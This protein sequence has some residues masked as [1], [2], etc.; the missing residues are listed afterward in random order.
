MNAPVTQLSDINPVQQY[1]KDQGALVK[2]KSILG[3]KAKSF[4]TTV[5]Q[6]TV[7]NSQL[8][9]ANPETVYAAAVTAATLDLPVN[10]NFGFAYILPYNVNKKCK[11]NNWK[12]DWQVEAQL[13]IGYKGFI[14]LALRS[15]QFKHINVCEVFADD[16][17]EQIIE[18]LTSL[19]PPR[20]TGEVVGY[21]A[22]FKLLNGFEAHCN[23]NVS[24]L[25]EH[26]Y[27]YSKTYKKAVDD[28]KDYSTWHQNFDAM[29]KKTVLKQLLTSRAPLSVELQRAI[30]TDQA[31]MRDVDGRIEPEYTDNQPLSLDAPTQ[32]LD[33]NQFSQLMASIQNGSM[34]KAY[35]LS[36]D[37]GYV[38]TPDQQQQLAGA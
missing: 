10:P 33:Q 19:F 3:E 6:L 20:K 37:A 2:I 16:N 14:Q 24:E 9:F 22:W 13:Q 34:D 28:K 4:V 29:S 11:Q 32:S 35:V 26:A 30:E 38:L 18:R 8:A 36:G 7:T 17:D 1:F 27:K 25:K 23:M 5:L 15:N 31:V 12:D 21:V